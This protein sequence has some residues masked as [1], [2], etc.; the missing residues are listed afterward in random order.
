MILRAG[1]LVAVAGLRQLHAGQD[2]GRCRRAQRVDV[3]AGA[4]A[5]ASGARAAVAEMKRQRVGRVP[6]RNPHRD[7]QRVVALPQLDDVAADERQARGGRRPDQRGVVPGELGERLRQLLQP[8]VVGEAAVVDARIGPEDDFEPL[9]RRCAALRRACRLHRHRLRRER[10]VRHRRRRAA[11][12]ASRDRMPR[13]RLRRQRRHRRRRAPAAAPARGRR[14]AWR[15][16]GRRCR[17]APAGGGRR[18]VGGPCSPLQNSR[19]RSYAAVA[20]FAE[21]RHDFVRRLAAVERRDQRLNDAW[22]SHRRRA[23]RST[24][25]GSALPECA[26]GSSAAVSS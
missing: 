19:T 13:S 24:L 20:A 2:V 3:E 11:S 21:R 6:G 17:R 12:G 1:Q 26:S 16:A 15:A 14:A 7:A 22:P 4:V 5:D 10:G 9:R 8:G 25:R 23:R 18:A